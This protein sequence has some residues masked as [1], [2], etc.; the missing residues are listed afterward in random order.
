MRKDVVRLVLAAG[1]ARLLPEL[2]ELVR[3]RAAGPQIQNILPGEGVVQEGVIDVR[4]EP[5]M[6]HTHTHWGQLP[7]R[8]TE[9]PCDRGSWETIKE[10][11]LHLIS[12][13]VWCR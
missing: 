7:Q 3:E 8:T 13:I 1:H 5:A 9:R 2:G 10:P 6:T 4:E 11:W 12:C